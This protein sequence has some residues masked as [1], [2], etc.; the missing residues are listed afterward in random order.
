MGISGSKQNSRV[1][2]NTELHDDI[3]TVSTSAITI[4][5][6]HKTTHRPLVNNLIIISTQKVSCHDVKRR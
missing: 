3:T 2:P 4:E 1:S 5:G 6:V